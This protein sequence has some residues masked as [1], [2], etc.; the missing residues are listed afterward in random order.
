MV[1]WLGSLLLGQLSCSPGG[2]WP[3]PAGPL[4]L[5]AAELAMK[6]EEGEPSPPPAT[7]GPGKLNCR[8]GKGKEGA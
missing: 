6:E 4:P 1:W 3:L 2:W 5:A 7:A 8:E